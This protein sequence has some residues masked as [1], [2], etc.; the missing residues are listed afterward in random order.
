MSNQEVECAQSELQRLPLHEVKLHFRD[1][2]GVIG[3]QGDS[4]HMIKLQGP[5]PGWSGL[6]ETFLGSLYGGAHLAAPDSREGG[7]PDIEKGAGEPGKWSFFDEPNRPFPPNRGKIEILACIPDPVQGKTRRSGGGFK[8]LSIQENPVK[9]IKPLQ[10][11]RVFNGLQQKLQPRTWSTAA[12]DL[13]EGYQVGD[14]P[15]DSEFEKPLKTFLCKD[16][17]ISIEG[18]FLNQITILFPNWRQRRGVEVWSHFFPLVCLSSLPDATPSPKCNQ[19]CNCFVTLKALVFQKKV[20]EKISAVGKEMM[21]IKV[22]SNENLY[23]ILNIVP[24]RVPPAC[25]SF[26]GYTG[27]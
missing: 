13:H 26:T 14:Q 17:L 16:F 7:L 11:R 24:I 12:G 6:S 2:R 27:K 21:A 22:P 23:W 9:R 20:D 3:A 1:V 10:V 5:G 18:L 25:R 19:I 15:R 4:R 8:I